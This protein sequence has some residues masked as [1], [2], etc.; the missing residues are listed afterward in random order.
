[1]AMSGTMPAPSRP[2]RPLGLLAGVT[3]AILGTLWLSLLGHQDAV[4]PARDGERPVAVRELRFADRSDG[5]IVITDART[6]R[7]V[8]VLAPGSEGFV[9]GAMRG[10]VRE[11]RREAIGA[12]PPFRLSAWPDGRMTIEDTATRQVVEL[13]AFGRTN[14]EAF[15]KLLTTEE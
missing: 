8:E 3:V 15:L 14:A 4:D 2:Q 7:E 9:R 10:L 12:Q 6:G 1:M 5:A 11:R 13:T